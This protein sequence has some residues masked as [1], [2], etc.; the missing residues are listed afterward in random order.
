MHLKLV[1]MYQDA[2]AAF[3]FN[4]T[5][6]GIFP[7]GHAAELDELVFLGSRKYI[8]IPQ[9]ASHSQAIWIL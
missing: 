6:G 1:K 2:F 3:P 9:P 4:S 5:E 8:V 7:S